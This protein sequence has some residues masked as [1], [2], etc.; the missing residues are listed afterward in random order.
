MKLLVPLFLAACI[1]VLDGCNGCGSG[2]EFGKFV[3][4]VKTEWLEPD[5]EMKLLDDFAYVEPSGAEWRAPAGSIVDGASIPQPLWSIV[6]SPFTGA[7]RNASVVHDVACKTRTR[8]W[9]DVHLMFYNACRCGGVDEVKAKIMYA[10]VYHF[11]PMWAPNGTPIVAARRGRIEDQMA[12]LKTFVESGNPSLQEIESF[13][14]TTTR[15]R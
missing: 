11:G 8:P 4:T 12:Q 15:P 3:G 2:G 14:P 6:G 5:R 10:A 1:L 9:R 13:A 7:Y